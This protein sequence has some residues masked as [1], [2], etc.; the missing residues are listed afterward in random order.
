[1][2]PTAATPASRTQPTATQERPATI[3][4]GR[5]AG[6]RSKLR[7]PP[8]PKAPRRVSGPGGGHARVRVSGPSRSAAPRTYTRAPARQ[9]GR[10]TVAARAV[11]LVRALP[12]HQL[13]DR[14][15]RGRAWIPIL[16]ILL[17]GIVAMQVEV[18]KLGA[19]MGAS[20]ERTSYLQ[21]RNELLRASVASLA[22]DRRIE[23]LAAGMGMIMPAPEAIN[24][25]SSRPVGYL[26]RAASS[27]RLPDNAT[28]LASLPTTSLGP[29]TPGSSASAVGAA[30]TAGTA[31][32]S[33]TTASTATTATPATAATTATTA[34]PGPPATAAAPV[35]VPTQSSAS[36]G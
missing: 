4:S 22:D 30:G 32:T 5:A 24:F 9:A 35:T 36:G 16:G 25:L 27:I 18:L 7:S 2:T 33:T 14:I 28:F 20:I 11:S 3:P 19:R 29:T 8:A 12:E 23:S 31:S 21:S 13:L 6:H 17:A 26:D 15:V 34:T 1:M 10:G